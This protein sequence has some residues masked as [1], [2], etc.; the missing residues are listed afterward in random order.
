MNKILDNLNKL[1]SLLLIISSLYGLYG[2][3][4]AYSHNISIISTWKFYIPIFLL[5]FFYILYEAKVRWLNIL[6]SIIFFLKYVILAR[7]NF[8]FIASFVN[9]F[10]KS[11]QYGLNFYHILNIFMYFTWLMLMI[12][13]IVYFLFL[14]K[15]KVVPYN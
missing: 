13:P 7:E 12:V 3:Y 15:N 9:E 5:T 1:I 6:V 2:L 4:M 11:Y 10:I 8:G 14:K